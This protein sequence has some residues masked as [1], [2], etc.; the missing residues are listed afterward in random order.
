MKDDRLQLIS[1]GLICSPSNPHEYPLG[2]GVHI[3]DESCYP[4]Y[5]GQKA[6]LAKPNG[7]DSAHTQQII[8][9]LT[10]ASTLEQRR[11]AYRLTL[12][13]LSEFGD[14]PQLDKVAPD[15][16]QEIVRQTGH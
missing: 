10:G 6:F 14:C 8:V 7:P 12:D 2:F 13:C 15:V 1:I 9:Q 3:T 4:C 5:E 16:W 11:A